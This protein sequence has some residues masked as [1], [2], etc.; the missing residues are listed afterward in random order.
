[1]I[2]Q[3]LVNFLLFNF[4]LNVNYVVYFY[5]SM[6]KCNYLYVIQK[7]EFYLYFIIYYLNSEFIFVVGLLFI[8]L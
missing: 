1:M 7:L 8:L 6:V 3:F 2:Y 5:N 4:V